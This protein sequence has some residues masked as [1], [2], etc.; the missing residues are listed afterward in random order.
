MCGIGSQNKSWN[1]WYKTEQDQRR[2]RMNQRL[3]EEKFETIIYDYFAN[4]PLYTARSH[5]QYDRDQMFDVEL[6][7][8]FLQ[9]TQPTEWK[10]LSR[11]FPGTE[12]EAVMDEFKKVRKKRGILEVLRFGFALRGAKLKFAYFKPASGFNEEHRKKYEANRF[13]IVRQFQ[14]NSAHTKEIDLVIL[15]NGIPLITM[16]LKNEFTG[17]NVQHAIRQYSD[18]KQ[19]DHNDQFFKACLVHFAVDNNTVCMT[20]KLAG[21]STRFLPFNRDTKNPIIEGK[22][23]SS[24]LWENILQADSLLNILQNFVMHQKDERGKV[25]H[26]KPIIFPRYHQLDVVR[27]LLKDV[28]KRGTG[29]N[30]LV[31]HSAGS[32]KSKSISWLAH[33]LSNL[34]NDKNEKIYDSVI[35][36]TDR[37]VLDQQLQKDILEFEKTKGVVHAIGKGKTSKDLV[38]AIESGAKI[39]VSTLQKFGTEN[40]S[41]IADLGDKRFAII[42]D[43]AHSSQ[44]GENVKDLKVALTSDGQLDQILKD[45]EYENED[46][47]AIEL[48][49]LMKQRQKLPHLSFF[50]FTAT[51]KPKTFEIFGIK[52]PDTKTGFRAFHYYTMRQAIEERFI[53]DVLKNYTTYGTY[54]ELVEKTAEDKKRE[55]E[56]GKARRLL[57]KEVGKHPHAISQKVHIMLN[58]FMENTRHKINGTAKAMVVTSSRAHA[59]LYK[60]AFDEVLEKQYHN[61]IHALVAFSGKVQ[62]EGD[63]KVYTEKSMN[64][65]DVKD[66]KNA[67]NTDNYRILIVANKFQTGFDQP[68]LHTMYVDK[69]LGGVATVQTLSRLNRMADHKTDTMVIDFVNS[70][71]KV[72]EDFQDYYQATMLDK[73]TD[74]QRLYNQK[75]EIEKANVFTEEDVERFIKLFIVKKIKGD[76]I[77]SFMRKIAAES[78]EPMEDEEKAVFRKKVNNYI[79]SYSFLSQIITYLDADLEKFYLFIKLLFK[80][81]PYK[82]ESL[83]VE[84]IEMVDMDKYAMEELTSRNITLEGEDQTLENTQKDGHGK[85]TKQYEP[86]EIIVNEINEQFGYDFKDFHKVMKEVKAYLKK[87]QPL[88]ATM[89]AKN[90]GDV[91]RM[92]FNEVLQQAFIENIDQFMEIME[93]MDEDK[94]FGNH[95]KATLFD[96]FTKELEKEEE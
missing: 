80:C 42:V 27:E 33:Q 37:R 87:D 89:N 46:P 12:I 56:K 29:T 15:L 59:V 50:A 36:I 75:Y 45:E 68:K 63:D 58:H 82:K 8:E 91:K 83:P 14:Y 85:K 95:L 70:Q 31:Q 77:S 38:K 49:K 84:V 18:P 13:S 7:S 73:G 2:K 20:T 25:L 41:K 55:F 47:I 52:D 65:D 90:I 86:L 76:S 60:K 48:E 4:S 69:T 93:K 11:Q 17:Q 74:S 39:I 72:Q 71:E 3:N 28:K 9:T 81:L 22:Y 64:P 61:E 5:K 19:R 96:W 57:L 43:E 24:Y 51:P 79:R 88:R 10:K 62:I 67:F 35:V 21:K 44:T 23:A 32:G 30:Y 1:K 78:Y 53:L 94:A 54:F 34:F 66:I 92:K 40:I 26:D 6:L 16:E